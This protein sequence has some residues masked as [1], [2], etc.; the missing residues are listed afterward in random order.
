MPW[1]P[2]PRVVREPA[3]VELHDLAGRVGDRDHERPVEVFVPARPQQ[4][5][6]FE[7]P[8]QRR[9]G[10]AIARRQ[11]IAERAVGEAQLEV[12]DQLGRA[13]AA[14]LEV[15]ERLGARRQRRVVVGHDLL[16]HLV[17]RRVAFNRRW[18]PWH[19]RA[20]HAPGAR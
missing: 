16:Q 5:E 12:L 19:R 15:A 14:P 11:A 17:V 10:L 6:L 7:A 9:A 20:L 8:S 1:H 2:G 18:Q 3:P 13:Q 4:A